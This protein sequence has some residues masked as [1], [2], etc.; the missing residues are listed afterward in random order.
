MID[1]MNAAVIRRYGPPEELHV[2]EV[3][4]PEP[5]PGEVLVSVAAAGINPVD[6]KTREGSGVAGRLTD[7]FPLILGWD[8]AGTVAALGE[9]ADAFAVGDAVFG[10][11]RFPGIGGAY[12]EYATAPAQDLSPAP[13]SVDAAHAAAAPL[14]ALTAWQALFDVAGVHE[15]QQVLITAGAGGVGHLAVQLA[16]RA[17]AH[18]TATGSASNEAFVRG[19]GAEEYKDY[20]AGGFDADGAIYDVIVDLVKSPA[21]MAQSYAAIKPDGLVVQIPSPPEEVPEG[22]RVVNHLVHPDGAQLREIAALIDEGALRVE[23]AAVLPLADAAEAHRR[24]A[25]GHTRGKIVLSI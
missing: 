3:P 16:A 5:V 15:G 19:L 7:P 25:S 23:V 20:A 22:L 18:V 24:S 1:A 12:A 8:V 2:E 13:R 6:Y 4:R 11:I 14:V 10:L 9:G 17:G 21:T